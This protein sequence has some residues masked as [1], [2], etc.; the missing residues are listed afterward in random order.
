MSRLA[1]APA[2]R[3]RIERELG[4]G[5]MAGEQADTEAS[6][7]SDGKGRIAGSDVEITLWSYC[8]ARSSRR[9]VAGY[10]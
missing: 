8:P 10:R 4:V 7:T 2:D 6:W 1:D 5:G 9:T 3:Y